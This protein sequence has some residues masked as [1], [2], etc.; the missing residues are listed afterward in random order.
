MTQKTLQQLVLDAMAKHPDPW[1]TVNTVRRL[2]KWDAK[3]SKNL[4]V[5][6]ANMFQAGRLDRRKADTD[7]AKGEHR[8]ASYVYLIAKPGTRPAPGQPKT[9]V[10]PSAPVR[11]L[12]VDHAAAALANPPRGR[13]T[14]VPSLASASLPAPPE[15]APVRVWPSVG[16]VSAAADAKPDT[17]TDAG[18]PWYVVA[19][20]PRFD[21]LDQAKAY[22]L[23]IAENE[24]DVE[25]VIGRPVEVLR[26]VPQWE[27]A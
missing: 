25:V 26:L 27:R 15:A 20:S 17:P 8:G 24:T 13:S 11:P 7:S 19:V 4:P 23:N 22:A 18:A 5:T 3:Q 10:L 1:M 12:Q 2:A 21:D 9:T 14:E 6:M 16:Q